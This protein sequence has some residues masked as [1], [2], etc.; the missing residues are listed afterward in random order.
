MGFGQ[1]TLG[2]KE[3]GLEADLAWLVTS[4]EQGRGLAVEATS[5]VV[6]WLRSVDVRHIRALIHPDHTASMHVVGRTGLAPPSAQVD[7]EGRWE[8]FLPTA[9]APARAASSTEQVALQSVVVPRSS[10]GDLY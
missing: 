8:A 6:M 5:T 4:E 3:D 7:V 1:A 2:R 10:I 9:L